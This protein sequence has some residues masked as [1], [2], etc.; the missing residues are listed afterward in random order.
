MFFRKAGVACGVGGVTREGDGAP[1]SDGDQWQ[2]RCDE[3][4]R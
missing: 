4:P 1:S 3:Q 2:E